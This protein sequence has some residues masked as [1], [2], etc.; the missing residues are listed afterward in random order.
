MKCTSIFP[1]NYYL[2]GLTILDMKKLTVVL[3]LCVIA[4]LPA[5]SQGCVAIRSTGSTCTKMHAGISKEWRMGLSYRYFK[6]FR[7]F[8]GT[9]EQ[10]QREE[11]HTEVINWQHTMNIE[12]TRQFNQRWSLGMYVPVLANSRS[13]L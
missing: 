8:V 3:G 7:H 13:S 4:Y 5:R 9:D 10:K 6:S 2:S 11:Q 1:L 12:V